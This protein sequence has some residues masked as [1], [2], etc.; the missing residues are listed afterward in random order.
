M[1]LQLL[2]INRQCDR[3]R[4]AEI[5][6]DEEAFRARAKPQAVYDIDPAKGRPLLAVVRT[7][8]AIVEELLQ[9]AKLMPKFADRLIG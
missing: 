1:P 2:L 9:W 5:L 7:V 6:E 8:E 4:C 3:A